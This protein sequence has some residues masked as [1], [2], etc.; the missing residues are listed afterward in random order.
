MKV[1]FWKKQRKVEAVES[2]DSDCTGSKDGYGDYQQWMIC[3]KKGH[4][5]VNSFDDWLCLRCWTGW[6]IGLRF[7]IKDETRDDFKKGGLVKG[8]IVIGISSKDTMFGGPKGS[9]HYA[10][11]YETGKFPFIEGTKIISYDEAI[12]RGENTVAPDN[13]GPPY[14]YEAQRI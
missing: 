2:Q 5:A 11:I 8:S 12:A 7:P 4:I 3:K 10:E 14:V 13:G 6:F 9:L 1:F